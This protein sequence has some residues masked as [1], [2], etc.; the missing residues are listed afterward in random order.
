[1]LPVMEPFH[2]TF[3]P[4]GIASKMIPMTLDSLF[5]KMVPVAD[6][7]RMTVVR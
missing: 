3:N 1:M 2:A 6:G 5:E 7:E 4:Q